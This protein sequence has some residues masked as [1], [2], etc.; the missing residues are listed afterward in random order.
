MSCLGIQHVMTM[1]YHPQS[2]G[3]VERFH[4]RLKDALRARAATADWPQHLPWVLLG[5]RSAPRE[6]SGVSSAELVFGAPL[7]LPR[8]FLST[9]EAPPVEFVQQ[10]NAG[11]PCVA[12]LPPP[13]ATRNSALVEQ[14]QQAD[15][16]YIKAPPTAPSLAPAYRGPY[17][18]HKRA[19]NFFII[20]L[21]QHYEAVNLDRLK[22]HLG[23]AVQ[24]SLPPRLGRPPS[25]TGG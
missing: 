25:Q 18:V 3:V 4:R 14:L 17:S 9:A 15:F 5:L 1:A 23:V 10:L 7:Q 24:P 21:G 11:V 8:Q 22:P 19:E 20:K 13:A 6:D 2:N 12:P 16:V